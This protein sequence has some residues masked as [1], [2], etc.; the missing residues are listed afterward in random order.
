MHLHATA[1]GRILLAYGPEALRKK[2]LEE[3]TLEKFTPSTIVDRQVLRN[4]LAAIK[5]RG[6]AI[7]R[8]ER[9]P[10]IAAMAAPVFD[11]ENKVIAAL[12]V[13]GP[14]QRLTEERCQEILVHLFAAAGRISQLLGAAD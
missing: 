4:E 12:A 1:V 13:V 10:G 6:Y 9:E 7:N 11:Y 2:V 8:E 14:A 5:Q 3:Q